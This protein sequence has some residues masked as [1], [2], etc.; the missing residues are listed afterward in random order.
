MT[1]AMR[2]FHSP[3]SPFVRKV[4]VVAMEAGIADRVALLPSAA[5]PIQRDATILPAN[6]LGQVPTLLLADGAALYDSR[7]ICEYLDHEA[8]AGLFP[9][10]GPARWRALREQA[11][12]DGLMNAAILL[13]YEAVARAEGER[14]AAWV[15]GQTAKVAG[16]LDEMARAVPER[17]RPLDIGAI[18]LGC[19][20]GYLDFR[21]AAM[22]WREG[23][24]DLAGWFAALSE[25]P[26]FRGTVPFA[27]PA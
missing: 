25:R 9:A 6:P 23:R 26:S 1:T 13:R 19:A 10:P 22:D 12:A 15:E 8:R 20:L 5:H 2:L 21:F 11:L 16:A 14:S 18:S 24:G 7:A 3:G 4:R 17:G 27:P